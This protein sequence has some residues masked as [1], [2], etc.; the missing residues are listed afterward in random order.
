MQIFTVKSVGLICA[1]ISL[2]LGN[3]IIMLECLLFNVKLL[4]VI[5]SFINRD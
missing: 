3:F 4:H 5:V 1:C 2:P